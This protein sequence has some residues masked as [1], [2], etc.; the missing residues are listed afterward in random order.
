MEW[1]VANMLTLT[2][3]LLTPVFLVAFVAGERGWALALF[4]IAGFTDLIDGTVARLLNQPTKGGALLDPLADKFLVESCFFA[5]ATVGVIPWW[6]FGLAFARDAMIVFGI[7]YL[8]HRAAPLPYRPLWSSKFATLF[9]LAVAVLGLLSWMTAERG[10]IPENAFAV[11]IA[12][13]ALLIV[14]SG[15]QYVFVGLG[16]LRQ[17]GERAAP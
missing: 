15:I 12:I 17:A 7:F 10:T 9:Q 5:L 13:T 8:R 16:L 11:V 4:C 6:F 1:T 14:V 2:R 3:L